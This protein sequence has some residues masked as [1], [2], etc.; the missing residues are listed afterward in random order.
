MAESEPTTIGPRALNDH[1]ST[2]DVFIAIGI[3]KLQ[4]Y[5]EVGSS[6]APP[7]E[8]SNPLMPSTFIPAIELNLGSLSI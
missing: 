7:T 8:F 3:G 6:T 1:F 5:P 4:D 2:W